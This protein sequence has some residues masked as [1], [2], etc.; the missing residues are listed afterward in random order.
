LRQAYLD[1][2]LLVGE[3]GKPGVVR[4]QA[5]DVAHHEA[6]DELDAIASVQPGEMDFVSKN[7]K[8]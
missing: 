5:L 6:L 8:R 7:A 4:S 1:T 3:E 2:A